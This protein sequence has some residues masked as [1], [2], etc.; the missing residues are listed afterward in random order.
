MWLSLE[1]SFLRP[2]NS[3]MSELGSRFSC[4][5][6]L[7]WQRLMDALTAVLWET[8][9][10]SHSTKRHLP[11][12]SWP[13]KLWGNKYCCK[14]LNSEV[15]CYAAIDN[16]YNYLLFSDIVLGPKNVK[17]DWCLVTLCGKRRRQACV[18]IRYE[19]HKMVSAIWRCAEQE[20]GEQRKGSLSRRGRER[21]KVTL[22]KAVLPRNIG[23]GASPW[24]G[25]MDNAWGW[26]GV[27]SAS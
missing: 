16:W 5:W 21:Q 3:L 23:G 7:R 9:S 1:V 10:P 25:D 2:A 15:I 22:E 13:Q 14:L 17:K 11:L 12:N 20:V 27:V 18:Q 4:S 24:R 26:N 19:Q 8:L 6:P